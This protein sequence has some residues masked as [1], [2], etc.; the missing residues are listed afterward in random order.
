MI[1]KL[2]TCSIFFI[3][4][5]KHG[6]NLIGVGSEF[7]VYLMKFLNERIMVFAL[8]KVRKTVGSVMKFKNEIYIL[9]NYILWIIA[10][11]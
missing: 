6:Q 9:I 4:S 7:Y 10:I 1:I 3:Q 5:S 11:K 8:S 2:I